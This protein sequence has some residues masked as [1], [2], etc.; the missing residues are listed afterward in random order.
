MTYFRFER[1]AEGYANDRPHYNPMVIDRIRERIDLTGKLGCAVDVGCGTG[2]STRPL[3]E[4]AETVV[5][6]DASPEMIKVARKHDAS[7]IDYHC[8]PAES[9][10]FGNGTV[11]LVSVAGAINWIDCDLFLPE[12]RRVLK[13]E[14][15]LVVYDN[16]IT[17]R[18]LESERYGD[19]YRS[20]FLRRYPK[21]P[22]RENPLN[23]ETCRSHGFAFHSS[24]EYTNNVSLSLDEYVKFMLIQSNVVAV[25]ELGTGELGEV[26]DW[27]RAEVKAIIPEPR[28]T[29]VFGGYITLLK[30]LS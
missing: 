21:P 20:R 22:R 5:G 26:A 13:P 28:G 15:W 12:V 1:V 24:E 10:P 8:L 3:M 19:W 18:M 30:L 25:V 17:D 2:L 23:E 29:F 16:G 6:T 27:I 4:I 11:D 14:G 7:G 9:I